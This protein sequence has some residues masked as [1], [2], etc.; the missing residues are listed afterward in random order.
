MLSQC[1]SHADV[2]LAVDP[3]HFNWNPCNTQRQYGVMAKVSGLQFAKVGA[4]IVTF[5]LRNINDKF[6]LVK[7]EGVQAK[8]WELHETNGEAASSGNS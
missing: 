2:Y 5:D 3:G 8:G 4:T 7:N 6:E 1:E